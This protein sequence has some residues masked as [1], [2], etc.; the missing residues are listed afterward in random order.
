MTIEFD[1]KT[2]SSLQYQGRRMHAALEQD[3]RKEA[4]LIQRRVDH[5]LDNLPGVAAELPD[6]GLVHENASPWILD[7]ASSI[8]RNA[9]GHPEPVL[10]MTSIGE[11]EMPD[12]D[13]FEPNGGGV[14]LLDR[15]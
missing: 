6:G 1:E 5:I 4:E 3:D 15:P 13:G 11:L 8:V 12:D 9:S 10:P 7:Q 14:G 2:L